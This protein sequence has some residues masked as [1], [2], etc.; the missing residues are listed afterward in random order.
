MNQD[1]LHKQQK[2]GYWDIT[3]QEVI[4][5]KEKRSKAWLVQH[6][7]SN[8]LP[9]FS[10]LSRAQSS[11]SILFSPLQF[12]TPM[13]DPTSTNVLLLLNKSWS[14]LNYP[15]IIPPSIATEV[16]SHSDPLP[17]YF[18]S[19]F[20][21]RFLSVP[22]LLKASSLFFLKRM[23]IIFQIIGS[24]SKSLI[25]YYWR[26]ADFFCFHLTSNRD[27]TSECKDGCSSPQCQ[28]S[29]DIFSFSN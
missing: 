9:W 3:C 19:V 4:S 21:K 7:G 8:K 20:F 22:S 27:F 29:Q 5:W 10:S 17:I 1:H 12:P 26:P 25:N 15:H 14:F 18:F 11:S 23:E 13:C 24:W 16:N 6:S 28:D 2:R